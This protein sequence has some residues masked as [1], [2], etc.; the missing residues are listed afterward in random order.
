MNAAGKAYLVMPKDGDV[1]A[2][3]Y[4]FDENMNLVPEGSTT[5]IAGVTDLDDTTSAPAYNLSGQ[6]VGASY[7]GIVIQNGKKIR[8]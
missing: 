8:K 2:S 4:V 7:R 3:G 1:M 5:G 6:R